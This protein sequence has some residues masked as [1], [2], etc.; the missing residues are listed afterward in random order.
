MW[1]QIVMAIMG[2]WLMVAPGVFNYSKTMADN[3]HIVGPLI[4]T[5]SIIATSECTRNVR[6]FN[7]PLAVW[8]L[9]APVV[10]GFDSDTALMNDYAVAIVIIFLFIVKPKRKHRFG[11]GWPALWRSGSL[12]EREARQ[13]RP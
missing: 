12:H 8:L 11:G 6:L 4:A 5:C 2:V 3:A 1:S 7:L 10:I 9:A 13:L